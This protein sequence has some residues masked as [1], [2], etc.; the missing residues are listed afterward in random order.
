LALRGAGVEPLVLAG[1][2]EAPVFPEVAFA[3]DRAEGEDG[4]SGTVIRPRSRSASARAIASRR[5]SSS[6]S[7]P[8]HGLLPLHTTVEDQVADQPVNRQNCCSEVPSEELHPMV[9]AHLTSRFLERALAPCVGKLLR[10]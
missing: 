9:F 8:I 2:V 6:T 3:D 10:G 1:E 4:F 5:L 7:E